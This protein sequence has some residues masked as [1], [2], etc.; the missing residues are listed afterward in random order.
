MWMYVIHY[1]QNKRGAL[2][3]SDLSAGLRTIGAVL[4]QVDLQSLF[5]AI[6]LH[7]R[8]SIDRIDWDNFL[9]IDNR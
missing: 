8:G 1:H 3:L 4:T 2:S 6:D 9:D 7:K 5:D